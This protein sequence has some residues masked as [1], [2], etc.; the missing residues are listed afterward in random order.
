MEL[1]FKQIN[2]TISKKCT[3]FYFQG[4]RRLYVFYKNH[5]IFKNIYN[6]STLKVLNYYL[7]LYIPVPNLPVL[8]SYRPVPA[9]YVGIY[10]KLS[11]QKSAGL[12]RK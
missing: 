4:F 1:F 5:I 8:Y 9:L 11:A 2:Y 12:K 3:L 10:L 6:P 7:Y